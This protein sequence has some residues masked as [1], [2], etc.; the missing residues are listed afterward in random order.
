[1]INALRRMWG[2]V[3]REHSSPARLAAA[4]ALGIFIGCSP[5]YGLHFWIGV[6]LAVALRL[7]KLAVF[8]GTQTVIPPAVP[9]VI[10]CDVQA[11]SLLRTGAFRALSVGELT[12]ADAPGAVGAL[13]VDWLVGWPLVGGAAAAVIFT[14]VLLLLR[15]RRGKGLA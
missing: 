6:S 2:R 15:L 13:L 3:L 8:F 5:F 4:A 1:M 10:F 7:N 11:G 14:V 9:L 12:A